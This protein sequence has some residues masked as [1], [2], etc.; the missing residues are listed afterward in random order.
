[1]LTFLR[2]IRKSLVVSGQLRKYILYAIG[3]ILLVMIGILLA[4]QVNNWNQAKQLRT[5]EKEVILLLYNEMQLNKKY[6][7]RL[8]NV[9]I[10]RAQNTCR[11]Y[12]EHTGLQGT[13]IS[14]DTFNYQLTKTS[15]PF[16]SPITAKFDQVVNG[17]DFSLIQDD[18]LRFLLTD[19]K[20]RIQYAMSIHDESRKSWDELNDYLGNHYSI[21]R[22]VS[23]ARFLYRGLNDIGDTTFE[24]DHDVILKDPKFENVITNRLVYLDYWRRRVD[25]FLSHVELTLQYL[26]ERLQN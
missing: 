8:L 9:D 19:Y 6:L 20:V 4:L 5:E 3:E 15:T 2:K 24:F 17:A 12:L 18:S 14:S 1:M 22:T 11:M 26:D 25:Q 23:I 21:R 16:F 10:A 13:P 7:S